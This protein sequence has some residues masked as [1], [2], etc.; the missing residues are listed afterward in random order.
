MTE[1]QKHHSWWRSIPGVLTAVAGFITAV[2]GLVLAL[3][4]IGIFDEEESPANKIPL[5]SQEARERSNE[6]TTPQ[7][8]CR[9]PTRPPRFLNHQEQTKCSQITSTVKVNHYSLA[10]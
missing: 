4:Q 6:A 10:G 7:T 3:H 1:E 9:Q 8:H 2:T 5:I